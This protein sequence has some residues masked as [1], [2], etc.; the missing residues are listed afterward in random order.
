MIP[1]AHASG[2]PLLDIITPL[3]DLP[4]A[5][6]GFLYATSTSPKSESDNASSSSLSFPDALHAALSLSPE[7]EYAMRLRAR[8]KSRMFG[9][10][11]FEQ[12]WVDGLWDRLMVG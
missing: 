9:V 8:E 11:E 12:A 5:R 6:T 10:R 7:E 2:G 3:S 1:V 4:D